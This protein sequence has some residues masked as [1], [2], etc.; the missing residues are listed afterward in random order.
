MASFLYNFALRALFPVLVL[1]YLRG[2]FLIRKYTR[3][4]SDRLGFFRLKLN[5]QAK[6]RFLVHAVSVGETVAAQP[7]VKGLRR[8]FPGCEIIFSNVTETGHSRALD[9]INADHYVFFPLDY[10]SA[11]RR[12]LCKTRP[13]HVFILETELWPNFLSECSLQ[14]IPVTFING[15]ISAHS[16]QR[17]SLV[18]FLL[19]GFL[20]EPEFFMQSRE[21]MD[22]IKKLGAE[23]VFL[24]GNLKVDQLED[25]LCS[26]HRDKVCQLFEEHETPIIIFGSSHQAETR[27]ILELVSTWRNEGLTA[28]II[29]APRH[30][31]FIQEYLDHANQLNLPVQ[32]WSKFKASEDF[33]CLMVDGYGELASLYEVASIAVICGSFEPIGGHSILEPA[34]FERAILYGPHMENNHELT[35]IF[36]ENGASLCVPDF[37]ELKQK[38]ELLLADPPLRDKLGE[39]A[40]RIV[41]Q[42]MGVTGEILDRLEIHG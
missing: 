9:S 11:V 26:E 7:F 28:S 19:S 29:L 2:R 23:K 22:R 41:R 37:V 42:M 21:D 40:G 31:H 5:T 1:H 25:N 17:Y 8:R 15:R 4:M 6:C 12:F 32:L 27:H 35:R 39:N 10:R 16:Y 24:S 33:T 18:R 20:R 36:E 30:L 38:I 3:P 34:L 13:T 14:A